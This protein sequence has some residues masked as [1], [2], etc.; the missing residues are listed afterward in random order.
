[1]FSKHIKRNES[2]FNLQRGEADLFNQRRN[3][4][5][6]N[7]Y[8]YEIWHSSCLFD[9][10]QWTVRKRWRTT[11]C[12]SIFLSFLAEVSSANFSE[13]LKILISSQMFQKCLIRREIKK[14]SAA[15]SAV[16]P[17]FLHSSLL[18]FKISLL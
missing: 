13:F 17:H 18:L 9:G 5:N 8:S 16:T 12:H 14:M 6:K 1:M 10:Q 7:S 15:F 4:A 11:I 3:S 2:V